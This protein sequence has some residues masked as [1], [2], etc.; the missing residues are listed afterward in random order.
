MQCPARRNDLLTRRH[1]CGVVVGGLLAHRAGADAAPALQC[2]L[3]LVADPSNSAKSAPPAV[4][5]VV[6]NTGPQAL[7]VLAWN[8]PF[9]TGWFAPF[10]EI[11]RNQE[12]LPYQGAS[13]KRG[14]PSASAYFRL[15]AGG[16]REA[17]VSLAPAFDVRAAGQYVIR[18]NWQ[19]HDVFRADM[20]KPPRP[21][22]A[23]QSMV[24]VANELRFTR[25]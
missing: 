11:T 17:T 23:H 18:P 3:S 2:T 5:V 25:P 6:R 16:S 4:Q 14:D 21:R 20:G 22:S 24:V 1:W 15:E 19:W 9:D 12:P 13:M 10:F 7:Q 8:S